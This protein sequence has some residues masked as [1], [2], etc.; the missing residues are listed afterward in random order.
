MAELDRD[1]VM[2]P[3]ALI[4]PSIIDT[5][6]EML[7]TLWAYTEDVTLSD[8]GGPCHCID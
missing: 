4:D 7:Y 8:C 6:E 1:V 2:T 5:W 3:L